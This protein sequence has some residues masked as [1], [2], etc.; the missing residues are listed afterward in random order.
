MV[1]AQTRIRIVDNSGAKE[2][3]CIRPLRGSSHHIAHIGDEIIAVVKKAFRI[4]KKKGVVQ[5]KKVAEKKQIHRVLIV[6]SSKEVRRADGM[7]IKF[8]E[9]LGIVVNQ[10][11]MPMSTRIKSPLPLEIR[12][13][14][15]H[16]VL[17]LSHAYV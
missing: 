12:K 17:F 3:M 10:I 9:N 14:Q 15:Y 8:S 11:G 13:P 4:T 6:G 16:K 2:V 7:H 1:Q 5:K